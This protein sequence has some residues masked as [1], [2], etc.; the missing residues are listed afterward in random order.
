[1]AHSSH[2]GPYLCT[3]KGPYFRLRSSHLLL[4]VPES[5][6]DLSLTSQHRQD[7]MAE[8]VCQPN[9]L[10]PNPVHHRLHHKPLSSKA[11]PVQGH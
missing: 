1:M 5:G 3:S 9:L 2:R 11:E 8:P 7:G 6:K 4:T 10:T